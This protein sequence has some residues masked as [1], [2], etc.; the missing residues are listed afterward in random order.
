[1]KSH[2]FFSEINWERLEGKQISPPFKPNLKNSHDLH[3][4]DKMFTNEAA[5]DTPSTGLVWNENYPNFTYHK[6]EEAVSPIAEVEAKQEETEELE[7]QE[8]PDLIINANFKL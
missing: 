3:F 7:E 2:P 1:M 6:K 4:F 8:N 5:K